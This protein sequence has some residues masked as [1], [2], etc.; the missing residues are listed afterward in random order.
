MDVPVWRERVGGSI[1][2]EKDRGRE[3][4]REKGD[5]GRERQCMMIKLMI[6]MNYVQLTSGQ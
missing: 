6:N 3:R 1:W 5:G 2:G 4:E